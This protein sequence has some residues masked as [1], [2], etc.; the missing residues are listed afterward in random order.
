MTAGLFVGWCAELQQT[1]HACKV[2]RL[3]AA[4]HIQTTEQAPQVNFHRVLADVQFGGDVAVALTTI[5]HDD[6][7]FLTLG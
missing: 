7:L 1:G 3:G 5:E 6:E 4:L 2:Q